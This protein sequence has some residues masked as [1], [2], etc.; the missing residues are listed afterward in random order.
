MVNQVRN[1]RHGK[2]VF[3]NIVKTANE[4][5]NSSETEFVLKPNYMDSLP[6]EAEIINKAELKERPLFIEFSHSGFSRS[7]ESLAK[8]LLDPSARPEEET[9]PVGKLWR[10]SK[11]LGLNFF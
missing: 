10:I 6:Y 1:P 3:E 4:N 7:I 8:V 2:M 11:I 5:I 9:E